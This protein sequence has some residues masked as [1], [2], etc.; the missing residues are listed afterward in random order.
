M[1]AAEVLRLVAG[2]AGPLLAAAVPPRP[3]ERPLTQNW[4]GIRRARCSP[5]RLTKITMPRPSMPGASSL[6]RLSLLLFAARFYRRIDL[7]GTAA[8]QDRGAFQRLLNLDQRFPNVVHRL[9][10]GV[11]DSL[12]RVDV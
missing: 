9:H 3:G 12:Q 6:L 11:H 8:T 1:T 10:G 2:V 5:I 7:H 4:P